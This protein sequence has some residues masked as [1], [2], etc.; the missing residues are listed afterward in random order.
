MTP[1][2]QACMFA[3]ALPLLL[4]CACATT[5]VAAPDQ[6]ALAR[7]AAPY[8]DQLRAVGIKRVSSP[9]GGAMVQLQTFYSDVYVRY[10]AGVQPMAFVLDIGVDHLEAS[11]ATFDEA[12]YRRVLA[13]LLPQAVSETE[14]NNRFEWVRANPVN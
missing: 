14:A 7:L 3:K 13:A 1:A 10:P 4:L 12:Q 6:P 5:P 8:A 11:S 2:F 9:G